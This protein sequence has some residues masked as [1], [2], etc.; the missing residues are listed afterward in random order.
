MGTGFTFLCYVGVEEW[1]KLHMHFY[2]SYE[3]FST[4]R[5]N[6]EDHVQIKYK[7]LAI[8]YS[9]MEIMLVPNIDLYFCNSLS[10]F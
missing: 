6:K 7:S 3:K 5:L 10:L 4:Y 1:Y 8:K 2:V 9:I